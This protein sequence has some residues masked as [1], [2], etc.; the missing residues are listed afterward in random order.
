MSIQ[1]SIN[2]LLGKVALLAKADKVAKSVSDKNTQ[3]AAPTMLNKVNDEGLTGAQKQETQ[4]KTKKIETKGISKK[5]KQATISAEE[6]LTTRQE[7]I[8]QMFKNNYGR[9]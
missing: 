8:E 2:S 9:Y 1:G 3:V 7:E 4:Q 6:S 5:Q